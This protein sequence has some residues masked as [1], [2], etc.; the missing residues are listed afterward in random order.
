VAG[1]TKA[2]LCFHLERALSLGLAF[3][4]S[5]AARLIFGF[6]LWSFGAS[7]ARMMTAQITPLIIGARLSVELVTPFSLAARLVAYTQALL[8]AGGGVLTPVAAGFCARGDREQQQRLVLHGGRFCLLFAVFFVAFFVCAGRAFLGLW[9]GP[10]LAS[11][12]GLLAILAI[13]ETLALSQIV[14]Q[15]VILGVGRPRLLA[16]ANLAEC[17]SVLLLAS[18]LIVPYGIVGVCLTTAVASSCCRGIFLLVMACRLV[19]LPLRQYLWR[20][21]LLPLAV[22][23][24]PV[25]GLSLLIW[26]REP[27]SWFELILYGTGYGVCYGGWCGGIFGYHRPVLEYLGRKFEKQMAFAPEGRSK[28]AQR[29]NAGWQQGNS[30]IGPGGTTELGLGEPQSSLRD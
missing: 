26:W 24:L 5:Q 8:A 12:G 17:L 29:F 25:A 15:S 28:I 19:G 16:A 18:V 4:N 14:S 22:A 23:A 6:G 27:A 2:L 13:G 7:A 11:A 10:E 9:V 21:L 30:A 20:A 1:T 3:V